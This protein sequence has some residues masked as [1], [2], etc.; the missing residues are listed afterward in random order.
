[1]SI[2]YKSAGRDEVDELIDFDARNFGHP[3]EPPWIAAMN[4]P[5]DIERFVTARNETGRLVGLAGNY[6]LQLH[7]AGTV[8]GADGRRRVRQRRPQ[9]IAAGESPGP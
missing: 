1:M 3:P 2:S 4:G 5:I 9:P 7:P 6:R 8:D